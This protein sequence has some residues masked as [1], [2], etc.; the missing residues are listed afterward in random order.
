MIVLAVDPGRD[1]FEQQG[2]RLG[3]GAVITF[4]SGQARAAGNVIIAQAIL[5]EEAGQGADVVGQ[6]QDLV[7][8]FPNGLMTQACLLIDIGLGVRR[9]TLARDHQ[10]SGRRGFLDDAAI[11]GPDGD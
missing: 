7:L 4:V 6:P 2:V 8:K 11:V 5:V 10:Q 9:Q 3:Q 1:G